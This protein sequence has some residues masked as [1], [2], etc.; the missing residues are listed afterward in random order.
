MQSK[1]TLNHYDINLEFAKIRAALLSDVID[2]ITESDIIENQIKNANFVSKEIENV[3]EEDLGFLDY[4][5]ISERG[6]KE[7]ISSMEKIAGYT[8]E[9]SEDIS[10]SGGKINMINK[11][12]KHG[13]AKVSVLKKVIHRIT[14]D[15]DNYNLRMEVELP[16]FKKNADVCL[17]T[18]YKAVKII[19]EGNL[20]ENAKNDL[21]NILHSISTLKTAALNAK[22]GFASM[23]FSIEQLPKVEK[24]FN[25]SVQKTRKLVNEIVDIIDNFAIKA[26]SIEGNIQYTLSTKYII[27]E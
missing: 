14:D 7:L 6:F 22:N 8:N 13:E 27:E 21:L 9:V 23:S 26:E 1:N 4:I 10:E 16:I 5:E 12:N 2:K 25:S 24:N 11:N 15:L 3:V 19:Y 20:T 17:D 18:Y